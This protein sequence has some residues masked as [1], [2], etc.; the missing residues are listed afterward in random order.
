MKTKVI[1]CFLTFEVKGPGPGDWS[2]TRFYLMCDDFGTWTPNEVQLHSDVLLYV[3]CSHSLHPSGVD[4]VMLK[5][6]KAWAV[7]Y[8]QSPTGRTC[9][10]KPLLNRN[11][12]LCGL[13][14]FQFPSP[15]TSLNA[16]YLSSSVSFFFALK[17]KT[18]DWQPKADVLNV[19]HGWVFHGSLSH[20][21]FQYHFWKPPLLTLHLGRESSR[22][23]VPGPRRRIFI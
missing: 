16:S 8:A 6:K 5:K 10:A 2:A 9:F 14:C 7:Q 11:D 22:L 17:P 15:S 20:S 19:T 13:F 21:P 3:L 12:G 4:G 18:S 1:D 23:P